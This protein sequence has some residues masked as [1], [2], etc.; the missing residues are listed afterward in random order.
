MLT[1]LTPYDVGELSQQCPVVLPEWVPVP[2]AQVTWAL[3][4]FDP[5]YIGNV[6]E[7]FNCGPW[8][9]ENPDRWRHDLYK[10]VV[11]FP[12]HGEYHTRWFKIPGAA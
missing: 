12:D 9:L 6:R 1:D 3:G 7:C 11:I 2:G 8:H 10:V 4:N 5:E